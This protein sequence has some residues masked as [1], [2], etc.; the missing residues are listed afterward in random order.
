M[1]IASVG[2][3]AD[4]RIDTTRGGDNV[5][6]RL[7]GGLSVIAF[8][9]GGPGLLQGAEAAG[10]EKVSLQSVVDGAR[11]E[12]ALNFYASSA[13]GP[14]GAIAIQ[15][16]MKKKYGVALEFHYTPS[17]SMT[18]DVAKVATALGPCTASDS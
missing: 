18:R 16:A 12:G 2:A 5:I 7:V 4:V 17:G 8:V 13:M 11:K 10:P 1:N 9:V 14:K 3:P 15:D 6:S